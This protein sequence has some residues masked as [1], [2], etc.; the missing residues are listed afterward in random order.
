[1]NVDIAALRAIEA[2][3]DI[4]FEAVLEA[5]ES[6]LLTAYKHT[7]GHQPR[8][9]IDIDRKTG[10][11]RVLAHTLDEN[12]EIAEEWDDTPEGF[13]RIAATTARQVILQRLRDAE[14]E[15]TYGEFSAKEGEIVAG[16]I[17]RD[18]R[19]NARGMVVV[20]IGG[21]T[22]GVL[23]AAEQVPGENYPHG[24]RVKAY[25]WQVARSARGPQITLSR[26]HPNLVRKLFALEVPEIA[27]G[28][29]EITA[30]AREP[31]HRSKI[32]VRST[33]PGV[34]AKGACI[35]PVGA[36]VRNVMSE[37][38]GE[39]IDIIDYSDDP[40]Q[41]VGNALSPAK[42]V[43]VTVVDERTKTARVV[44]P[45]F[46][47]SLAIGKEG[48]NARLAARLTGWRIDIRSDAAPDAGP[49]QEAS[50]DPQPEDSPHT[51]VT[52]STE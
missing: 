45:D 4:P 22:E 38:G 52:G 32:S 36:R 7:E 43:S 26:T 23:P 8:A 41:F 11:V 2:D 24:G 33:V 29:V 49:Q 51:A 34:N 25:V 35:G 19:A 13:G 39:K 27:D 10:Y 5:I 3:K 42:A 14:Q 47:L 1:M 17:Q 48:Q 28:T 15:K 12:G 50:P 18:A 31:G 6:A 9:R 40:A 37:L 20:D 30:V 44:V 16:V 46:Q 21:D